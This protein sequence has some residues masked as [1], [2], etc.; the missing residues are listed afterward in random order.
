MEV[1]R[2]G[3][4]W[5]NSASNDNGTTT[6]IYNAKLAEDSLFEFC[7]YA[8]GNDVG[9]VVPAGWLQYGYQV[10]GSHVFDQ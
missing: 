8:A 7:F 9:V 6:L 10:Y 3:E 2:Q 4:G 1:V 5:Y